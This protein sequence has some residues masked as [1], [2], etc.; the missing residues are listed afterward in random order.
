MKSQIP[1]LL[2]A[3]AAA[4]ALSACAS[5]S[6]RPPGE[7]ALTQIQP[8]LTQADV[9]GIAGSPVNTTRDSSTGGSLWIYSFIDTWG[10]PSE[11][12]VTFDGTGRVTDV[13]AQRDGD[14]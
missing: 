11:L 12:D 2:P 10:Y 1:K 6:A 4:L 7:G 14:D 9:R 13:Y 8:G 5:L 3:L